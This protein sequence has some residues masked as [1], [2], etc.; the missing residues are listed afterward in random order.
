MRLITYNVNSLA[1][2]LPRL[3]ALLAEHAPDVV[4]LQETKCGPDS[5]PVEAL[6]AAGYDAVHRSGGRWAGV[7]I[8]ARADLALDD[9]CADLADE[10]DAAEARWIEATVGGSLR[11]ASVYVP[12]GR[13]LG[14]PTFEAKLRF[15]EAMARRAEQLADGRA[16]IAG[17]MNVCPANRDVWDVSQVHGAT[18]VTP[19]ERMRL[20]AVIDAGFVDAYRRVEPQESGFTWWDYRA[21]HFHKGFGLRIDLALVS[22]PLVDRLTGARVDRDYRKPTKVRESKPSDHAPLIVDFD[23]PA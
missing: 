7:A 3:R 10:P 13:A 1:Q 12:N 20:Q 8:L 18:H 11:V 9:V 19:D 5:F 22:Q 4:C 17:D 2:R 16:V 21:G 15:L 23:G 6:R 14:T